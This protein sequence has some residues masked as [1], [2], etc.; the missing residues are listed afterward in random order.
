MDITFCEDSG[1]VQVDEDVQGVE[2]E[3]GGGNIVYGDKNIVG[4][5]I[6]GNVTVVRNGESFLPYGRN[7]LI[8]RARSNIRNKEISF[9]TSSLNVLGKED[10]C[11]DSYDVVCQSN[12]KNPHAIM[13]RYDVRV[14]RVETSGRGLFDS[15]QWYPYGGQERIDRPRVDGY[16]VTGRLA[17]YANLNKSFTANVS[18]YALV[19]TILEKEMELAPA[20]SRERLD[21]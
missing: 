15:G 21:V 5:N 4:C 6:E 10:I 8:I 9:C 7:T 18:V 3:G 12:G 14:S 20:L 1:E 17:K 19:S 13:F 16:R 11:I 2:G